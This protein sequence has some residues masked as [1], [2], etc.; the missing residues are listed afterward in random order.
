MRRNVWLLLLLILI[1]TILMTRC[2]TQQYYDDRVGEAPLEIAPYPERIVELVNIYFANGGNEY[3]KREQRAIERTKE[4]K[5]EVILREL[6]D[7]PKDQLLS[8]TIPPQT[9]L[10]SVSTVNGTSYVNLS[11]EF[12]TNFIG[13]DR[14]EVTTVYSI[15]NTLTELEHIK[16]VQILVE[17]ERIE[18]YQNNLSLKEP[19]PRNEGV[20]NKPFPTPSETLETYFTHLENM[21]YRRAYDLIYRPLDYDLDYAIFYHYMR[22]NKI[23]IVDYTIKGYSIIRTKEGW[24]MVVD[25]E[26][27]YK[28][29]SVVEKKKAE[30]EFKNELGEWQMIFKEI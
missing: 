25:Y 15:V 10:F 12:I 22:R 29:G 16:Q 20:I 8:K 7:G 24:L 18:H 2:V 9:R 1:F 13:G 17:G 27:K 5:E 21:E 11:K 19:Y 28:D 30:F 14:A 4:S 6:I 26:E 3:L 23:E